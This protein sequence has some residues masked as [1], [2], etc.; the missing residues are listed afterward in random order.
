MQFFPRL[1]QF[2]LTRPQVIERVFQIQHRRFHVLFE[3]R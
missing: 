2:A 1:C 3:V